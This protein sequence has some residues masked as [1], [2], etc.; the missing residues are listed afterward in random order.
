MTEGPFVPD[1]H[2]ILY[3]IPQIGIAANK[4]DQ[5]VHYTFPMH[6]FCGHEWEAFLQVEAHLVAKNGTGS[7]AGSISLYGAVVEYMLQQVMIGLHGVYFPAGG[8]L[9]KK[10]PFAL[11][12]ANYRFLPKVAQASFLAEVP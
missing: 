2:A 10:V 5:L 8:I 9:D 4:P 6:P 12:A 7:C 11:A 3:E 1:A